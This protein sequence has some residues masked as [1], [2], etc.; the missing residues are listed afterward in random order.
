MGAGVEE[1]ADVNSYR[2][3][4]SRLSPLGRK[5]TLASQHAVSESSL[6]FCGLWTYEHIILSY[7]DNIILLHCPV[8]CLACSN[9]LD[10]HPSDLFPPNVPFDAGNHKSL[11]FNVP[12]KNSNLKFQVCKPSLS[13]GCL[14]PR[15]NA[16]SCV[17][18]WFSLH[19]VR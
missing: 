11:S 14:S 9:S 6:C 7:V 17:K 19:F 10:L 5:S 3:A 15:K 8:R 18:Q 1:T 4:E 2:Y 12:P 13:C 16:E